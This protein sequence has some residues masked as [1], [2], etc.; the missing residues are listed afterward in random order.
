MAK[1]KKITK[2]ALRKEKLKSSYEIVA[3]M[4]QI[5][6]LL[7]KEQVRKIVFAA[8]SILKEIC[9]NADHIKIDLLSD[10]QE[11]APV[12]RRQWVEFVQLATELTKNAISV[13]K[14]SKM[15]EQFEQSV[16]IVGLR[17]SFIDTYVNN[18]SGTDVELPIKEQEIP[19]PNL[20]EKE[21]NPEFEKILHNAVQVRVYINTV[22]WP[23]FKQ[24]AE[25]CEHITE[26]KI[27]YHTFR[28]LVD[29][30]HYKNGGYPSENSK[31]KL[32]SII[33]KFNYASRL[34]FEYEF[35][36]IRE[37]YAQFG[38]NAKFSEE[39]PSVNT[40]S[41]SARI[42]A[43]YNIFKPVSDEARIAFNMLEDE[44]IIAFMF[45]YVGIY[46]IDT[47]V[48]R[49][50]FKLSD[51][52]IISFDEYFTSKNVKETFEWLCFDEHSRNLYYN[53]LEKLCGLEIL[54]PSGK[55]S[56][57]RRYL[58]KD[59]IEVLG[60]YGY[61]GDKTSHEWLANEPFDAN[62][63]SAENVEEDL[64]SVDEQNED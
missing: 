18:E 7:E 4:L 5:E 12:E 41:N 59:D 57:S 45:G 62:I 23:A 31:P 24:F 52:A 30:E 17:K 50:I 42:L 11:F 28:D 10:A 36:Q 64:Q 47:R 46:D 21:S 39:H 61:Y 2:E 40:F 26:G 16:F 9:E 44:H 54:H 55:T 37:L 63:E 43:K 6:H 56:D 13:D 32:W 60:E 14:I 20:P 35:P 58:S 48:L 22:L 34:M 29:W 33:N 53:T 27:D 3:P 1:K 15:N 38:I 19:I 25:A 49:R 51:S 8:D